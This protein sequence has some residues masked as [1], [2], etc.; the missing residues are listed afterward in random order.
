MVWELIYLKALH[1]RHLFW[2]ELFEGQRK[3]GSSNG[4]LMRK[5]FSASRYW[6]LVITKF[7]KQT[8]PEK[9]ETMSIADILK[10]DGFVGTK[11]TN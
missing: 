6:H 1:E 4:R 7:I 3:R 10:Q 5:S 2:D 8:W 11:S 9:Y